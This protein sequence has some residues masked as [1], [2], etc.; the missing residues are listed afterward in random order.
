[1]D[2]AEQVV[3]AETQQDSSRRQHCD[4]QHQALAE[5]LQL[6]EPGEST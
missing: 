3:L 5:P 1:V 2:S 6:G 4:R